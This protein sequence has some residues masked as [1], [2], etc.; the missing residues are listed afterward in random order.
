MLPRRGTNV[1]KPVIVTSKATAVITDRKPKQW[2]NSDNEASLASADTPAQALQ[3]HRVQCFIQQAGLLS[4]LMLLCR[5]V[6]GDLVQFVRTNS[7]PTEVPVLV[8]H[9]GNVF[10]NRMLTAEFKRCG[11][12]VPQTWHWL[13]TLP[14]AK[15]LLPELKRLGSRTPMVYCTKAV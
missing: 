3:V 9:N 15:E 13:D 7:K 4:R 11:V 10:D 8:A 1:A 14:L 6:A 12:A 5:Q 2:D